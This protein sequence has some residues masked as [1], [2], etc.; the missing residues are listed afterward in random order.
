[1]IRQW[2]EQEIT[3]QAYPSD[4]EWF[5]FSQLQKEHVV[6]YYPIMEYLNKVDI[7]INLK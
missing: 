3:T 5:Y 2:I 1:M 6:F 7:T 4:K